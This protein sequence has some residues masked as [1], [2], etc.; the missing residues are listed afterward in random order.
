MAKPNYSFEKRKR[1]A[2]KRAKKEAKKE[3]KRLAK[4]QKAAGNLPPDGIDEP[5]QDGPVGEA[6]ASPTGGQSGSGA[7]S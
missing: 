4:E 5:E 1:E 7:G 3:A 6:D 2:A